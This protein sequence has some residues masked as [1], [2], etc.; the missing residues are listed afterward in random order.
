[1]EGA[2]G[3]RGVRGGGRGGADN[4]T[5]EG[6]G[7]QLRDEARGQHFPDRPSGGCVCPREAKKVR[8]GRG[9][10][11]IVGLEKDLRQGSPQGDRVQGVPS[12]L[13]NP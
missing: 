9:K 1:M 2:K 12:A 13:G 7:E 5:D 3:A 6:N 4:V 11:G 10:G 8:K